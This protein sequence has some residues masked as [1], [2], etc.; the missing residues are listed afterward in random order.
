[1]LTSPARSLRSFQALA[2]RIKQPACFILKAQ[3]SG[4]RR[5]TIVQRRAEFVFTAMRRNL[6][7]SGIRLRLPHPSGM[8]TTHRA[9]SLNTAGRTADIPEKAEA[10]AGGGMR[11]ID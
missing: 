10:A 4:R 5:M 9:R 6:R 3:P 7:N 8:L 11:D 2:V 1:M